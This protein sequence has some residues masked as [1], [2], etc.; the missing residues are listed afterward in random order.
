MLFNTFEFLIFFISVLTAFFCTPK[1][2]RWFILLISSYIFY[3]YW[4]ASYLFIIIGSTFVDYFI[5]NA[6]GKSSDLKRKKILLFISITTN[7]SVLILFKYYDFLITSFNDINEALEGSLRLKVINLVLPVGISFYTFQTMSYTIDV[8]NG[9]LK[10]EKH[11]GIFALF[12]SFFPQLVAGP[13]ERA[14]NLL[15]QLKKEPIVNY[16]K[17]A[18]GAQLILWGLVK[19]VIVADRVGLIANEIFNNYEDYHGFTLII[20]IICFAFQIYCDFSGYSDIA[21]GVARTMGYDLMKNFNNPYF[22]VSLTDFWRRWHISLSTW[23][24][25]YL[26]IPLGG[27]RV[28]KWRWYFNLWITFFISGI[29]H[30][31]NWTFIIWGAI[32]GFGLILENIIKLKTNNR[33]L[34]LKKLWIFTLICIAWIFFRANEVSDAFHIL[35]EVFNF[36]SYKLSQFS[37]YVVPVS[38]ETVYSADFVLAYACIGSLLLAEHFLIVKRKWESLHHISKLII[39]SITI[40]FIFI[41]GVFDLSEFIY[42]QF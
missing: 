28:L 23:F 1:K 21:I 25:D 37:P 9:K 22:S 5:S 14:T 32:H 15:P 19:K 39:Y 2:Y 20:G 27:N 35:S 8:Y 6:I 38:H 30:G 3:G 11:L 16:S 31:S 17:L 12:V 42:F 40:V 18:S 13:I 34:V 24:K 29:W 7:L 41:F 4:K 36:S 26:Y 10:P 33:F